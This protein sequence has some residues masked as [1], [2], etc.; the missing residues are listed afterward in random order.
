MLELMTGEATFQTHE[1]LEHLAMMEVILGKI[2]YSM[3]I[4]AERK[5]GGS[6]YFTPKGDLRWP[7]VTSNVEVS[8]S[9]QR[10]DA[11]PPV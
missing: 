9:P 7:D 6:K 1:N 11:G 2:P 3:A 10:P 4:L 5:S 8:Q